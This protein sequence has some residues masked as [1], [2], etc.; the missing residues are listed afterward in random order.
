[1]GWIYTVLARLNHELDFSYS[2]QHF[3][4][5]RSGEPSKSPLLNNSLHLILIYCKS[6]NVPKN[7]ILIRNRYT[8][9]FMM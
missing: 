7:I 4:M 6:S 2:L 8:E 1:M 9:N 3:P 5:P